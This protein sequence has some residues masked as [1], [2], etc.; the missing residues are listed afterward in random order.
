MRHTIAGAL[1]LTWC[2]AAQPLT[3]APPAIQ[4]IEVTG[5]ES[6]GFEALVSGI[7]GAERPAVLAAALPYGIVIRNR[8]SQTIAAIDTVWSADGRVLLNAA[9]QFFDR[10]ALYIQPGQAVLA[11]P[12]GILENP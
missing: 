4:G 2:A 5:P 3:V 7:T 8:S 6:P 10:P 1:L 12:P 11:V 9:D